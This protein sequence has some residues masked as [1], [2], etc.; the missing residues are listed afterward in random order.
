[1]AHLSAKP[2]HKNTRFAGL[3]FVKALFVC[4]AIMKISLA[5]Y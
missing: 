3:Y 2:Y 1:M 4:A 5:L